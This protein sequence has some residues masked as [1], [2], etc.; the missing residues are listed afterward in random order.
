VQFASSLFERGRSVIWI[1]LLGI[2]AG[3]YASDSYN[4]TELTIPTAIVGGAHFSNMVVTP[5]AIL[6]AAQGTPNGTE[7]SYDPASNELSI[8]SVI[9]GANTYTNATIT[10]NS[11]LSVGSVSGADTYN[12]TYILSPVLQVLGGPVYNTLMFKFGSIVSLGGGMPRNVRDVYDPATHEVT[13]AAIQV[14]S[15]VYTNA[16]VTL[17]NAYYANGTGIPVPTVVGH[18]QA[19]AQLEIQAVGMTVGTIST[20]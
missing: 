14:G 7:D 8:P 1:L 17:G 15:T 10:V 20:Q 12:G 13:I 6:G 4:G 3:A 2:G 9:V 18:S 19:N 11:L 16:V 5:A